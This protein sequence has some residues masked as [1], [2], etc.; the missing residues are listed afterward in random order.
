MEENK[1]VYKYR[2]ISNEFHRNAL[3]KNEL[4]LSSPGDFNDPF[5]VVNVDNF[6]MVLNN[7]NDFHLFLE[8]CEY[9]FID[10]YD[11]IADNIKL[12]LEMEF[13]D[14][15]ILKAK[16]YD[17]IDF[18]TKDF[19]ANN[20][21]SNWDDVMSF[22]KEIDYFVRR[23][24]YINNMVFWSSKRLYQFE[25]YG[26]LSLSNTITNILMWSHY[27]QNH[28]GFSI[29][30]Y[31]DRFEKS[32]KFLFTDDVKY[33]KDIPKINPLENCN[34]K[35]ANP[36]FIDDDNNKFPSYINRYM[37]W[38]VFFKSLDWQNEEEF[39]CAKIFTKNPTKEERL[40]HYDKDLIAEVV[41]GYIWDSEYEDYY[42][43]LINYCITNSI[44]LYKMSPVKNK[45][46]LTKQ[47]YK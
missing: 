42:K 10:N 34:Y 18:F 14:K 5:D 38:E 44:P 36:F 40:Y 2:N 30:F 11:K 13:K 20:K 41:L 1:I 7:R 22:K 28:R 39:R 31:A 24:I 16:L 45:F 17:T 9:F 23:L 27:G 33:V 19:F 15:T 47:E 35:I 25:L 29:G 46:E 21:V 3:L 43:E 6:E 12:L 32:K 8:Y 26:I 37:F 4:Y